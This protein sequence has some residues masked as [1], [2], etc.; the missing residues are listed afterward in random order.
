MF[1]GM[2][3]GE[4]VERPYVWRMSVGVGVVS[5]VVVAVVVVVVN[6]QTDKYITY[7]YV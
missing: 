6:A 1:W 5:G 7:N 3:G 2:E 4:R